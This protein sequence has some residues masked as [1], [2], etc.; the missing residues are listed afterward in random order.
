MKL[1]RPSLE[2][3]PATPLVVMHFKKSNIS[4]PKSNKLKKYTKKTTTP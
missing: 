1:S 4:K 2:T 3:R